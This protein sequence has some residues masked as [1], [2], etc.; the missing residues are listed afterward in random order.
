M[1]NAKIKARRRKL[2]DYTADPRNP[3]E[4]SPV[5]QQM[6]ESSLTEVGTGR[7]LVSA[8]DDVLIAGSHTLQAAIEA[9]IKDVIE[10]ETPGD[11]LIVHK[12]SDLVSTDQRTR[13]AM[14]LDNRAQEKSLTWD[15]E[16]IQA[17]RDSGLPM[18]DLFRDDEFEAM[19][20]EAELERMVEEALEK[21]VEGKR[22]GNESNSQVKIALY[23]KDVAVF[24]RAMRKTGNINRGE[25][26]LIISRAYLGES[27]DSESG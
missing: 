12:R 14:Y 11:V 17:D 16:Q 18:D 10:I 21:E 9:G 23:T 26:L 27:D 3:N 4:G 7:S 25:A 19:Q 22:L 20:A 5:G 24:E 15:A 1:A 6:I 13:R 2:S 8:A